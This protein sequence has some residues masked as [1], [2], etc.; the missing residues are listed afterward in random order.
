MSESRLNDVIAAIKSYESESYDFDSTA[1]KIAEICGKTVECYQLDNYWRSES[2][3]TFAAR[4][5]IAPIADWADID[6]ARAISLISEILSDPCVVDRNCEA[7]GQRFRKTVEQVIDWVFQC[8]LTAE[9]VLAE[10]KK[11]TVIYL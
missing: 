6:D 2:L 8:D 7:L 9:E 5:T 1:A 3:E 4:L 11:D 10:L